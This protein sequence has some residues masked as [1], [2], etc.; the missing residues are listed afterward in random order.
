MSIPLQQLSSQAN[1]GQR[2]VITGLGAISPLGLTVDEMWRGL[3]AGRSGIGAITRFAAGDLRSTIAGEVRN[4]EPSNYVERK[5]ARRLD[6]YIQYALAAAKEA[7]ANAGLDANPADPER[8]GVIFGSA[9]GGI[10]TTGENQTIAEQRGLRKVSPFFVSNMLVD[11]AS[12]RIAIEYNAQG[13]NH[14]PI[15]ACATGTAACGE[16]YEILR[17][18]DADV[19]I[20]GGSDAAIT[21][22]AMAGFDNAG[23]LSQRNDQPTAASRPFDRQRDGFVMAE[24]AGALILESEAHARARGA[25]IY[26]EVVGYGSSA[27]AHHMIAPHEQCRGAIAAMMMA[28]RKAAANSLTPDQID[29]INA[30]GTST[31]RND[32]GETFAIKQVFG[33]HAYALAVS[34]T[35]SML[36]HMLGAAGAVEAIIC[37]QTIRHGIIPPTINLHTPDPECDLDYTPH[38]ARQ[39]EVYAALSNSF[40][41]GGHNACIILRRY[42]G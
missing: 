30:H 14:A 15:S 20:A 1:I 10:Q 34:S 16:A 38:T 12:G 21:P 32:A 9:L 36:G 22:L 17:R 26:A 24:G 4:F 27:D 5:E 35:K 23:A 40:G 28:L 6:L 31:R 39:T 42:D 7:M 13:I 29:Y 18:G 19:I 33:E 8:I 41:F 11:S 2:V 3:L 37:T 25:A